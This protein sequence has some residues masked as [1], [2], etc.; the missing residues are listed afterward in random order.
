MAAF[1]AAS[2]APLWSQSLLPLR[3]AGD[4]TGSADVSIKEWLLVPTPGSHPHDPLAAPGGPQ[5]GPYGIEAI[6]DIVWYSESG[7]QPNTLVRSRD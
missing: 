6:D 3:Q 2:N 4:A 7:K 1:L 5:S